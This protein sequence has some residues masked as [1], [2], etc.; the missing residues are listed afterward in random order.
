MIV[1]LY[2]FDKKNYSFYIK[3]KLLV[4]EK[5]RKRHL[6]GFFTICSMNLIFLLSPYPMFGNYFQ[7]RLLLI[8]KAISKPSN[9]N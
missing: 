4:S 7:F 6:K 2:K 8:S 9:F 5:A 1:N 3:G